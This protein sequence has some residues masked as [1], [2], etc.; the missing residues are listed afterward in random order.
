MSL[1]DSWQQQRQQRQQA[2]AQRQQ[3]VRQSLMLS[4][5]TRQVAATERQRQRRSLRQTLADN[6]RHRQQTTQQTSAAL[7][8]VKTRRQEV[9]NYLMDVSL[10]RQIRAEELNQVLVQN[11]AMRSTEVQTLFQDL[12]EFRAELKQF[13]SQLSARV[14]GC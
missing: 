2:L 8:E 6:N 4:G 5:K 14:W 1:K 10:L 13:R 12:A 7:S 3:V 9:Q 11:R